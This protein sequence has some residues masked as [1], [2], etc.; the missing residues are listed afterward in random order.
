MRPPARRPTASTSRATARSSS[1]RRSAAA[2]GAAAA[3]SYGAGLA[4]VSKSIANTRSEVCWAAV[5]KDGRYVF[6]TNFG[7]GTISSYAIGARRLARARR[8]G[9]RLDGPRREGRARRGAERRRPLP[10]RARRR[11]AAGSSR[12]PCAT[13]AGS[14]PSATSTACRRRRQGLAAVSRLSRHDFAGMARMSAELRLP[15]LPRPVAQRRAARPRPAGPVRRPTTSRCSRPARR[16]TRRSTS[17]RSRSTARSTSRAAG[18]GTSSARCRA[19]TI[20]KDIHCV[21]KWSKLDTDWE[22]VSV[23]TLLDGVE[24][25]GRVRRRVLRRRLHDEPAARGRHRRQGVG[26]VRLRRRA[27][28]PR[29]RRPGAAA[30]PAPLLLEER[31][32]G[33]RAARCATTT[34]PG[35]WERYGYHNYGDP[36]RE[37]RYWGD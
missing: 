27:A 24:T 17:G 11:R 15:R 1:P 18:R 5:T 23:D 31:E 25:D 9:R 3:S 8:R 35:F 34:S 4:P 21:T 13:T 29:A 2:V 7:D 37:Q 33:A 32:V 10:L 14:I 36:W 30:R 28:R 16:R 6:V 22:G 19:R 12:S 20:T 26:R